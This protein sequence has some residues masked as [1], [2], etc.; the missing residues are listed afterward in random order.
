MTD[1]LVVGFNRTVL[2]ESVF[3]KSD[4]VIQRNF[5]QFTTMF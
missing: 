2:R 4:F 3:S 1:K 5:E